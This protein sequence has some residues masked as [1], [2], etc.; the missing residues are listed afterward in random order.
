MDKNKDYYAILGINPSASKKDIKS[1]YRNLARK[2]HPDTNQ[3]NKIS[4]LKFKEIGEAYEILVSDDKRRRYD[5]LRGIIEPRQKTHEASQQ[6]KKQASN[7]Y[8]QQK[9]SKDS[10]QQNQKNT[11]TTQDRS[12]NDV[13]SEFLDGVFGKSPDSAKTAKNEPT[14]RKGSDITLDVFLTITEAHNG[15]VRKVNV[16]R[17]ETCKK[18][19]GLRFINGVKCNSCDGKGEVSNQK[20]LS[21]KIPQNVKTGSKIRIQGEGNP[22]LYGGENGDLFLHVQIQKNTLFTFDNLNVMCEIPITPSE[23]ALG[24]DIQVPTVDGFVSMKIPSGTSSG[25]KF[26]LTGQGIVDAKTGKAGDHII[27]ALIEVPK[28]LSQKEKELYIELSKI[29]KS[30]P[31][32]NLIFENQKK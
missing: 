29:R 13:F 15:S 1:A 21:V 19:K 4:E 28:D 12:F 32:E 10:S 16:L 25:Q 11:N 20:Q 22:G 6:T 14:P 30:N 9:D 26:K 18:C 5:L 8:S 17:T 31:R 27:T 7:A 23:A 24:A 3:G 2:Y